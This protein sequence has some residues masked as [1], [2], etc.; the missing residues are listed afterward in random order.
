[1]FG[2]DL[3][4]WMK[5]SVAGKEGRPHSTQRMFDQLGRGAA[6]TEESERRLWFRWMR[7][8]YWDRVG[9]LAING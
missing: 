1:M 5:E 2:Q 3:L 7:K 4:N 6:V 9:S 8:N